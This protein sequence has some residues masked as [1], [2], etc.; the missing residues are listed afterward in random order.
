LVVRRYPRKLLVHFRRHTNNFDRDTNMPLTDA[1]LR[2]LKSS[3]TPLK[4]SDAEGLYVLVTPGGSKL[5]RLAYRFGS[6][7]KTLALGQYPDMSLLN[8]RRARD[9]AKQLLREGVDPAANRRTE[10]RKRSIAA[11]NT[12]EAVASEWFER[13]RTRWVESYSLR[14]KSRLEVDLL[15]LLGKR[16]IAEIEPLEVLDAI[17]KIED[18]DAIETAKR[19]MQIASNIFCYGVATARCGRDPTGDLRGA[20]KPPKPPKHRAALP[21]QELSRFMRALEVYDGDI[22]TKLGLKLLVLTFV[23]TS[24]LRFASWSEFEGLDG[25]EPLWRIPADRMKMRRP[26][27]VPLAP[28]ARGVLREIRMLDRTSQYLFPTSSKTGVMSENT[29]LF[30]L[31]RMGYHKRATVHGFR[32]TASTVLNEAQFNRD[33]V[34]MQLAHFDGSVRGIYNAAE[35][36]PGRR[37]MMNWWANYLDGERIPRLAVA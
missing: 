29:L 1:K 24:E 35:W 26:H 15:P 8:A 11:A 13:N 34:E 32:S 16:P 31:Y 18:R 9:A 37:Q 22:A 33:W 5:W 3:A 2:A 6:K 28:Q 23:R 14:L 27:L 17:R 10:R 25:T 12:F 19:V 4:K 21:A 30:A 36:L 20:L 7:Q